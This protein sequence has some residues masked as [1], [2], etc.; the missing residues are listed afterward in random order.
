MCEFGRI[1]L[2]YFRITAAGDGYNSVSYSDLARLD[3]YHFLSSDF[4]K[5]NLENWQK[6]NFHLSKTEISD[7]VLVGEKIW[8][9][10]KKTYG[11]GP[12]IQFF[13]ANDK[14]AIAEEELDQQSNF[15][16]QNNYSLYGYPDKHPQYYDINFEIIETPSSINI[17]YRLL[18]SNHIPIKSIL[19]YI[20]TK[21]KLDISLLTFVIKSG[22]Q[23]MA[24]LTQENAFMILNKANIFYNNPKY[25]IRYN[26][27]TG[28]LLSHNF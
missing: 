25:I 2:C 11:G 6:C 24:E 5:L 10:L 13:L 15:L 28:K 3:I 20:A 4:K 16:Y 18:L 7:Y 9:M 26:G 21:L 12:T 17:P 23:E 19:Y 1:F 8:E 27:A 14:N 22:E